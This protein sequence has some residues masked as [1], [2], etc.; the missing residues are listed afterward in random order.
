MLGYK[1]KG[2]ETGNSQEIPR[3][4]TWS[5]RREMRGN[6]VLCIRLYDL[7]VSCLWGPEG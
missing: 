3:I 1:K 6:D 7:G 2:V 5:L 4:K